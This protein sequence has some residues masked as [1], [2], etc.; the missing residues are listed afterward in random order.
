M[1]IDNLFDSELADVF[2]HNQNRQL[3]PINAVSPISH[4]SIDWKW[5][6]HPVAKRRSIRDA[7]WYFEC[8]F[9]GLE[10]L[11]DYVEVDPSRRGGVPVLKG[12]RVTVAETLAEV[13]ESRGVQDVAENFDLDAEQ[14]KSILNGLSL[15]L[16]Q[17][18][19]R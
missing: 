16:N 6:T 15:L 11:R 18:Y 1:K 2:E 8:A 9:F 12:T 14:L 19:P 3:A 13:A 4:L 10:T 7:E 5:T 17:P